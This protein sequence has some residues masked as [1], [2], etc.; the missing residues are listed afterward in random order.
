MKGPHFR[1]NSNGEAEDLHKK[2]IIHNL[3]DA[4]NAAGAVAKTRKGEE[5]Q[6]A[7]GEALKDWDKEDLLLLIQ[8]YK[9]VLTREE[10]APVMSALHAAGGTF[11]LDLGESYNPSRNLTD[12]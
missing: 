8:R 11:D 10:A 3:E 12:K 6:D 9:N 7:L 1:V 4:R 2:R 5:Y